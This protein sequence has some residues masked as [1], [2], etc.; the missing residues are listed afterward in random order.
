VPEPSVFEFDMAIEKLKRYKLINR[1]PAEFIRSGSRTIRSEIH[2]LI[3]S[4]WN[5]EELPEEWKVSIIVPIYKRDDK[6]E[7]SNYR[8]V[9]F[10]QLCIKVFQQHAV[11]VNSICRGNYW[12]SSVW[13][14]TQ[15]VIY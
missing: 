3:A 8:G 2:K 7:C 9:S 15:E 10:C 13:I 12:R 4:S 1:I 5:K 14:S 11:K 6:T